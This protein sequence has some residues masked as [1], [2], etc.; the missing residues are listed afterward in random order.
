MPDIGPQVS[1]I[2]IPDRSGNYRILFAIRMEFGIILFHGF[3]KKSR[4]TPE[5]EK[6]IARTRLAAFLREL[7]EER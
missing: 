2:R 7:E 4:K 6:R 3:K 5:R 1:E